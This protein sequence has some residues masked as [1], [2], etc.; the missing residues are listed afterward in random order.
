[1]PVQVVPDIKQAFIERLEA[2]AAITSLTAGRISSVLRRTWTMP[3]YAIT[4]RVSGT[5]PGGDDFE[6]GILTSRIDFEFYGSTPER[7]MTLWRTAHPYIVP[8]RGSG[9]K[10]AFKQANCRVD[11]V[12]KEGGPSEIVDEVTSYPFVLATYIVTWFELPT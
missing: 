6:L 7:A 3:D 8:N 11:N 10:V 1:M 9:R 5:G 12:V 2:E 4:L